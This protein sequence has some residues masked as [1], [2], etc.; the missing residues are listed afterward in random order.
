MT[1]C[2]FQYNLFFCIVHIVQVKLALKLRLKLKLIVMMS[3]SIHMMTSQSRMCVQCVRN[4]LEV[5]KVWKNTEK[6][7]LEESCIR[8]LSV[9]RF[10]TQSYLMRHMN[11]HTSKYK[12]SECGKCFQHNE[13]LT[14][15]SRIH[16]GEKLF[17]CND[18][19]KRF[20]TAG[21]LVRHRR[22]HSGEKT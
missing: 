20:T 19:N 5:N 18:C 17:E 22:V 2:F 14:K 21:H 8:V 7:T 4:G 13:A 3:L 6:D 1:H 16:S 12:C 10:I 15:H 9:R 11:G